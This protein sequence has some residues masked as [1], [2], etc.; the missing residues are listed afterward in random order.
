[1]RPNWSK[2]ARLA[3]RTCT[4]NSF[5]LF[6]VILVSKGE[7]FYTTYCQSPRYSLV[8]SLEIMKC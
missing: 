2:L 6:G 3:Q 5:Q 1:M 7:P 4:L 8:E